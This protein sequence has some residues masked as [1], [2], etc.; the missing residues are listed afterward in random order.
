MSK[1]EMKRI[2]IQSKC[3]TRDELREQLDNTNGKL[4]I[5]VELTDKL[6]DAYTKSD[7]AIRNKVDQFFTTPRGVSPQIIFFPNNCSLK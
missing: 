6:Q 5:A 7:D 3:S 2:C 4:A 1:S